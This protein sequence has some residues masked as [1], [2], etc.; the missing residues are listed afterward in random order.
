MP[1]PYELK[2]R[3]VFSRKDPFKGYDVKEALKNGQVPDRPHNDAAPLDDELWSF[4]KTC[5]SI[6][7][8]ERPSAAKVVSILERLA[9]KP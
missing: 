2:L 8:N 5:W 6:L 1:S 7:P 4:L 3:Q 9:V